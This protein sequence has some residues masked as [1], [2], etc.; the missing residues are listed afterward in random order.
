[1]AKCAK[2]SLNGQIS[3]E[4]GGLSVLGLLEFV[5]GFLQ[6]VFGERT[7]Q[8]KTGQGLA[9]KHLD[10]GVVGLIP[11]GFCSRKALN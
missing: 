11:H 9:I 8:H 5:F 10:H 7:A 3:R 6:F 4:H 2:G 1:M